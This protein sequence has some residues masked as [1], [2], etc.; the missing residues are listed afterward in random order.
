ML[1][2]FYDYCIGLVIN[3]I[4]ENL[5]LVNIKEII[6]VDCFILKVCFKYLLF[7]LFIGY[8][9]NIFFFVYLIKL[10]EKI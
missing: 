5:Y 8:K 9:Y 1:F 10:V 7:N 3:E 2:Y 6:L 4:C